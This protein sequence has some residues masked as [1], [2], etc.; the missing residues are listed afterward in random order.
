MNKEETLLDL[1]TCL[2]NIRRSALRARHSLAMAYPMLVEIKDLEWIVETADACIDKVYE[3][4]SRAKDTDHRSD[5]GG[6]A[7]KENRGNPLRGL[8]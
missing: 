6:D 5:A 1:V 2:T 4:T 8:D 3:T 7:H